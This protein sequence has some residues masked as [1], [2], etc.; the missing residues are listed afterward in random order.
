M[1][2]RIRPP[3]KTGHTTC[4]PIEEKRLAPVNTLPASVAATPSV[5]VNEKRGKSSAVGQTMDRLVSRRLQRGDLRLRCGQ[6][7]A[8][9]GDLNLRCE[10]GLESHASEVGDFLLGLYVVPGD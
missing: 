1:F 3:A 8:G 10:S 4:G 7:C 2:D 9:L 6:E 5:P